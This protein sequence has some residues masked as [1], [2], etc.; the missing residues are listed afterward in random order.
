MSKLNI[1]LQ[2]ALCPECIS[3]DEDNTTNV[4]TDSPPQGWP[5]FGK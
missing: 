5:P 1:I 3:D 4:S 2:V